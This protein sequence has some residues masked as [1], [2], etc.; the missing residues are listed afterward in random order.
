MKDV[1]TEM[2]INSIRFSSG[3]DFFEQNPMDYNWKTKRLP[4][5]VDRIV[6]EGWIRKEEKWFCRSFPAK[7]SVI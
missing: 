5:G 2:E 6:G 4:E 1:V 7:V 3:M